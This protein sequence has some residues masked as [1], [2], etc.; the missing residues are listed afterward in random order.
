[1]E[2]NFEEEKNLWLTTFSG[3]MI[4]SLIFIVEAI[5]DTI[6]GQYNVVHLIA[7]II[8]TIIYLF[9]GIKYDYFKNALAYIKKPHKK[10]KNNF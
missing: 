8:F 9:A 4:A 6:T 10:I 7:A 5:N 2:D 3:L 1:M